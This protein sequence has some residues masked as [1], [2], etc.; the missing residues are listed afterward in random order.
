MTGQMTIFDFLDTEEEQKIPDKDISEILSRFETFCEDTGAQDIKHKYRVWEHCPQYG[1]RLEGYC[2]LLNT[3]E[4]RKKLDDLQ[5]AMKR[6]EKRGVEVD[7]IVT[8][9]FTIGRSSDYVTL[10]LYTTFKD[11]RRKKK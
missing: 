2:S 7:L 1:T 6:Y 4:N 10:M 8:T 3:D 11:G 5:H 9:C